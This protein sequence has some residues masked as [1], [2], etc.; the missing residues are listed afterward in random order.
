LLDEELKPLVDSGVIVLYPVGALYWPISYEMFG[1]RRSFNDEELKSAWPARYVEEGVGYAGSLQATYTAL[2]RDEYK[3][4][5]DACGE[6]AAALGFRNRRLLAALPRLH[7]PFFE[8]LDAKTMISA[9]NNEEA[10]DGFR[11]VIRK[12]AGKLI[13][14]IEDP[15]FEKEVADWEKNE[16]TPELAR[17]NAEVS[18]STTLKKRLSDIFI[19]FMSG[20]L[21]QEIT[22]WHLEEAVL[23]GL[24]SSLSKQLFKILSD[25][26]KP[27]EEA[28]IVNL[29][30]TGRKSGIQ[31]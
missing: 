1:K 22:T 19:D 14:G 2:Y 27:S 25:P 6:L 21:N 7:L 4:L 12:M 23:K 24:S 10:F 8:S 5:E 13:S 31:L 16:L 18:Q 3:V 29:F 15:D 17:L 28:T 30:H 9:R 11:K 20:A 26:H